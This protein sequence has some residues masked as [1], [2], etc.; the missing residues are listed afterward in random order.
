[1][2]AFPLD[3]ALLRNLT[4]WVVGGGDGVGLINMANQ[5]L[6]SYRGLSGLS[7]TS[8]SPAFDSFSTKESTAGFEIGSDPRLRPYDSRQCS[9]DSVCYMVLLLGQPSQWEIKVNEKQSGF[10][11]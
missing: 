9:V 11:F 5:C 8:T 1:M 3:P 7:A 6:C 10:F 2:A 4:Q